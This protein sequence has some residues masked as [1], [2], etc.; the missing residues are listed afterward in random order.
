MLS[1]GTE[2]EEPLGCVISLGD[3]WGRG[4]D[5]I[6]NTPFLRTWAPAASVAD[7]SLSPILRELMSEEVISS[8]LDGLLRGDQGQ[9]YCCSC[10][11]S[12]GQLRLGGH[13]QV[14]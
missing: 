10:G 8:Q 9:V 1:K 7:P 13:R 5:G 2:V 14:R 11:A 12:E 3:C 4:M 6:S